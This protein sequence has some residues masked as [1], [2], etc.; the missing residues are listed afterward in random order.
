MICEDCG[1]NNAEVIIKT[2]INGQIIQKELCRECAQGWFEDGKK[3]VHEYPEDKGH[4][5]IRKVK[6]MRLYGRT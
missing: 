5:E 2:V 1:K 3:Q 4:G 6:Y